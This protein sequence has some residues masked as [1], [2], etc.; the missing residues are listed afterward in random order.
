[1]LVKYNNRNEVK[2]KVP[3]HV[4]IIVDGN[5]RWAEARGLSRSKGHD[6]GYKNLKE[7]C[8]YIFSKNIEILSLYLFR[9]CS[10]YGSCCACI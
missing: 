4:A 1:M 10:F 7:I 3:K 2:M 8:P 5:G 6:A 9:N